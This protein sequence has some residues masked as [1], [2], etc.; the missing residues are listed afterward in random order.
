[1]NKELVI[2][3]KRVS[4][5]VF[6][7]KLVTKVSSDAFIDLCLKTI[8]KTV[9]DCGQTISTQDLA[10][11]ATELSQSIL[12]NYNWMTLSELPMIFSKGRRKEFGEWFGLNLN[13]FE[14]WI[15]T[16]YKDARSAI[17]RSK[18]LAKEEEVRPTKEENEKALNNMLTEALLKYSLS[19]EI[20]NVY[21]YN[22]LFERGDLPEHTTKFKEMV[23]RKALKRIYKSKGSKADVLK[24]TKRNAFIKLGVKNG[25][26]EQEIISLLKK[27]KV[28]SLQKENYTIKKQLNLIVNGRKGIKYEC[29]KI[30]LELHFNKLL[31]NKTSNNNKTH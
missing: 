13:T 29:K 5:I 16:Y 21:L 1:M 19:R 6:D 17:I 18:N 10:L 8:T 25:L 23:R 31:H 24:Q 9:N 14:I 7:S 28:N 20:D 4:E 30:V 22:S 3:E 2:R 15:E 26:S 27:N 11:R 12:T